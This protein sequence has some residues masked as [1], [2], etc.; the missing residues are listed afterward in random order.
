MNKA[1]LEW[2]VSGLNQYLL[3]KNED[4]FI[5]TAQDDFDKKQ[6]LTDPQEARLENLYKEKSKLTPNKN[7]NSYAFK[8]SAPKKARVRKPLAKDVL[9]RS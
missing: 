2:V 9:I 3:T 6:A 5:K 8:E 1:R 4:Q 7:S